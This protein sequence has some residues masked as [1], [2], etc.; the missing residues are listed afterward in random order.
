[1]KRIILTILLLGVII[2]GL[3]GCGSNTEN[4]GTI[5]SI[6]NYEEKITFQPYSVPISIPYRHRPLTERENLTNRLIKV[7]KK[8]FS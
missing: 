2:I 6:V 1:M 4:R 5:N 7:L 8:D 3:T